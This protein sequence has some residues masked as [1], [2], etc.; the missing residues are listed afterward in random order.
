MAQMEFIMNTLARITRHM[1]LDSMQPAWDQPAWSHPERI[2]REPTNASTTWNPLNPWG[3][4]QPGTLKERGGP[5]SR[6][7]N[8]H[9]GNGLLPD[10]PAHTRLQEVPA[11][12]GRDRQQPWR[13]GEGERGSNHRPTTW[14]MVNTRPKPQQAPAPY[15]QATRTAV[16]PRE[17][18]GPSRPPTEA[19]LAFNLFKLGQLQHHSYNWETVPKRILNALDEAF[20]TITPPQPDETFHLRL[21]EISSDLKANLMQVV[22]QHLEDKQTEMSRTITAAG[23][24]QNWDWDRAMEEARRRLKDHFGKKVD[25]N[26][27]TDLFREV[28]ARTDQTTTSG[29]TSAPAAPSAQAPPTTNTPRRTPISIQPAPNNH[30]PIFNPYEALE[31]DPDVEEG[32]QET[33]QPP[34]KRTDRRPSPLP[35]RVR[36]TSAPPPPISTALPPRKSQYVY[37]PHR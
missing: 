3:P 9:Q 33:A 1:G 34:P 20:K 12:G 5:A 4:P 35:Q 8:Q 15:K 16:P 26:R 32:D 31:T 30:L 11:W 2:R 19:T 37:R 21:R 17:P 18:M 22:L 28:R 25:L 10:P 7:G 13:V 23:A 27:A 36:G 6:T 29:P 14:P 24:E